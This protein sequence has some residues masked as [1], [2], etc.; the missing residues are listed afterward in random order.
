MITKKSQPKINLQNF[1]FAFVS[2]WTKWNRLVKNRI[3]NG[4]VRN[5]LDKPVKVPT[6]GSS[7]GLLDRL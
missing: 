6:K 5:D 3:I 4:S 2:C 7:G 1:S